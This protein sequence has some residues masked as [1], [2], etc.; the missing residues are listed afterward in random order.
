MVVGF[1][2]GE[3]EDDAVREILIRFRM[4]NQ[5]SAYCLAWIHGDDSGIFDSEWERQPSF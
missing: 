1:C 3:G 4:S 5:Q 2:G